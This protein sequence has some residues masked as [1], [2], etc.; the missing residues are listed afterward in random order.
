MV[1]R[2]QPPRIIDRPEP[3][4]IRMR[5]ESKGP[6]RAARIFLRLGMLLAEIDLQPADPVHVWHGGERITEQEYETL[7]LAINSPSPF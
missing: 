5:T 1:N 6:Y 3:C 7:L 2:R 4:W